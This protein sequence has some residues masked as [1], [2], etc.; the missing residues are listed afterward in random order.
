VIAPM[1]PKEDNDQPS[2]PMSPAPIW[3][4][5]P[6]ACRDLENLQAEWAMEQ[7]AMR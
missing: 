5:F 1:R 3:P 4:D 2:G 6:W 7:K